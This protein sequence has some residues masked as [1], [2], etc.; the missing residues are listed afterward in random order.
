MSRRQRDTN[1]KS[2][3]TFDNA[4]ALPIGE[5]SFSNE[6]STKR[7]QTSAGSIISNE[8]SSFAPPKCSGIS[9]FHKTATGMS[10]VSSFS[11][12]GRTV[13]ELDVR[14]QSRGEETLCTKRPSLNFS[15]QANVAGAES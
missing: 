13:C 5:N 1:K 10:G 7:N 14:T 9:C 2:T 15:S 12:G 8:I 6:Q 3:A 11:R 4:S